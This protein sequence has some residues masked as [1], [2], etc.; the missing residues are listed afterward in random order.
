MLLKVYTELITSPVFKIF[1]C[2]YVYLLSVY[3]YRVISETAGPI[4]TG[5]KKADATSSHLDYFSFQK[6]YNLN[7]LTVTGR[8]GRI[9]GRRLVKHI[10]TF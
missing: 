5:L 4:L 2:L 6:E 3:S 1:D 9:C 10:L 7:M 8:R